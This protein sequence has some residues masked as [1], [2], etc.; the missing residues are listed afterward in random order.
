MTTAADIV[1]LLLAV[2]CE[3]NE[4]RICALC[5][6]TRTTENEEVRDGDTGR[7]NRPNVSLYNFFVVCTPAGQQTTFQIFE[8]ET[9]P[10]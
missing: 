6:N 8:A 2:H 4:C 10:K 9:K 1:Y 3:R 7:A 5:S